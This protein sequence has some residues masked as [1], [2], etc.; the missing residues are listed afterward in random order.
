MRVNEYLGF[1]LCNLI[2]PGEPQRLSLT[3]PSGI[4]ELQQEPHYGTSKQA[5]A[6]GQC[7]ETYVISTDVTGDVPRFVEIRKTCAAV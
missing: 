5:I 6:R 7:A 4:W 1:R 2:I 3:T